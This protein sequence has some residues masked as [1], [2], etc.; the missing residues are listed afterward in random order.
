MYP[1]IIKESELSCR[2][3]VVSCVFTA[4]PLS[5]DISTL[6][7]P[8]SSYTHELTGGRRYGKIN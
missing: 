4:S 7:F 3:S 6:E 1:R 2:V 8:I 5:V